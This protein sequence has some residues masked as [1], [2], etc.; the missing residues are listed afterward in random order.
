MEQL[1]NML[2][3]EQALSHLTSFIGGSGLLGALGFQQ[4]AK[5]LKIK[6]MALVKSIF[7]RKK[8][9]LKELI[10]LINA[11]MEG[12]PREKIFDEFIDV[13]ESIKPMLKGSK[14]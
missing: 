5:K 9:F 12:K 1:L 6:P 13:L 11:Y 2:A 14:K 7:G 4:L 10:E 8:S 3:S